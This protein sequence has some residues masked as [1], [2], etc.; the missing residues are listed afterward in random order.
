M[1]KHTKIKQALK[2]ILTGLPL[3]A[4]IFASLLPL[5][6]WMRQ[7]LVLITLVWFFVFYL[8]DCLYINS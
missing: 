1:S 8:L 3:G 4:V 2:W 6:P 7:A 5:A